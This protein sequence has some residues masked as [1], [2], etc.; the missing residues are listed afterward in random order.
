MLI[1]F[2]VMF[3]LVFLSLILM[4]LKISESELEL[5]SSGTGGLGNTIISFSIVTG[6]K[7]RKSS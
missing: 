6:L 2:T 1:Y 3:G 7:S 4:G 5:S